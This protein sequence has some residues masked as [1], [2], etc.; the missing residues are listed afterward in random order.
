[1]LLK[2]NLT[3]TYMNNQNNQILL[4]NILFLDIETVPL[5]PSFDDVPETIKP[6]WIQKSEHINKEKP[7][8]EL[9]E[10]AGIY[11]EFGKIVCISLGRAINK[12]DHI[13]IRIKSFYGHDEKVILNDFFNLISKFN[14]DNL[15]LC[16][17]NGK[18]FD[19]PYIAR[20][21]IINRIALPTILNTSGIKPWEIKHIDTMDMWRFGDYKNFTSLDLLATIF[22]IPSPKDEISGKDIFRVYYEENDLEKIAKYCQKDVLTLIQ[23]YLRYKNLDNIPIK[24]E[25]V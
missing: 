8:K 22:N 1:M 24:Y 16:A 20:R 14:Q 6:F 17:H 3:V 25:L 7:A 19:F 11:A 21:A 4:E 12:N 18:E 10:R 5:Y 2:E 13:Y 15:F 9:Y 23:V